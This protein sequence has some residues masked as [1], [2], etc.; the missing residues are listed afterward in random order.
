MT[1]ET[2]IF[3][4]TN[5][6]DL[7]SQYRLYKIKGLISAPNEMYQNQQTIIKK[8]S[9]L[10]QSPVTIIDQNGT[11][12]LVVSLDSKEP[13]PSLPLVRTVVV[14]ERCQEILTLDYT[15]RHPENDKICIR[16][17]DFTIQGSLYCN[18]DL[19]QP[20]AGRPF[21]Y[22][23][24]NSYVN[25]LAHYEGFSARTVVTPDGGLGICVEVTSK[26]IGKEPLPAY[27]TQDE[28]ASWKNRYF[29]Y[30]YGHLWYEIQLNALSDLTAEEYI[31]PGSN[32]SVLKWAIKESRKPITSELAQVPYDSAVAI[33]LNNRGDTRSALTALCYPVYRTY[34]GAAAVFHNQSILAPHIRRERIHNFA[35]KFL[36]RLKLGTRE[37]Q[38]SL[39]S[40]D[41]K[42][43]IFNVPDLKFGNNKVLSVTGT[44]GAQH[45]SLDR[46]GATRMSLL[47]D[48]NAGVF[49]QTPFDRQYLILPE[50]VEDSYGPRFMEDLKLAVNELFP[51][52]YK[53][54]LV[55]YNDRVSKTFIKQGNAILDA[56]RSV[57]K[58]PGYA[59]VMIHPTGNHD[60]LAEDQLEAMVIR[61]L[62]EELDIAAA[63]IHT[64]TAQESYQLINQNEQPNYEPRPE[65]FGKLKG[66]LRM[67]ALNKI[68]LT[69][70]RWPFVLNTPLNADLTIGFDVK[71]NT[72]GLVVISKNGANIRT[73]FKTSKQKEKLNKEQFKA[74]LVEI[75]R[76]EIRMREEPI[77]NIVL[78]R[79]GRLFDTELKGANEAVEHL[80][81]EH[82][83][84]SQANLTIIEIPKTSPVPLRLF[85]TI[86][87]NGRLWVENPQ[88]GTYFLVSQTEGY[89]C[90]TGRAF[91][92]KGT[93]HPLHV[94]LVQGG[95][96]LEN[97]LMDIF[98]LACL[99]WM[100][101]DDCSRYPI[102]VK[103]N[104]RFLG[105]EA[106]SYDSDALEADA[107]LGDGDLEDD[108]E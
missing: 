108:Y 10:L 27:L 2:N 37:V 30:H 11:P 19:W 26:T 50:S 8:L 48:R 49:S 14:F 73:L 66:Y 9:Y 77:R 93:V 16:F 60:I 31:I 7:S 5:L 68:L 98:Y 103:L 92:R 90:T 106:T 13:P 97:C 107:T 17:L 67:V 61:K 28:F 36:G 78:Q 54:V 23:S 43:Q 62:R 24:A 91:S 21:F 74:Y 12:Y 56:V 33:Y 45:V 25:N 64:T 53:P 1:L 100:R 88:I 40:L 105:E 32:M 75:L 81:R 63:V 41:T 29:V 104:D 34:D 55:T 18:L 101:P 86:N 85:D 80:K 83:L 82:T 15:L 52:P 71:Q 95:L 59:V 65:K 35:Q 20:G 46:L 102:T 69:N 96:S 99:T 72:T 38:V 22:K 4:I 70:Q 39:Q 79:D 94:K 42:P 3:Q 44:P 58:D 89:L 84:D 57:C 6:A 76:Q 47:K 87:N 51:H